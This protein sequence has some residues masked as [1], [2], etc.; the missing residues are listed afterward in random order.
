M[1]DPQATTSPATDRQRLA[2]LRRAY[3][4]LEPRV[5]AGE[6]WPLAD[7]FGVEPEASWGPREVLAHVAEMLPFWLGELDRIVL[8]RGHAP[9]PFGRMADDHLRIG[10][11]ERDRTLPLRV[12]FSGIDA[13]LHDWEL[14]LASL[15]TAD[16]AKVGVHVRLG[17]MPASAIPE[18][19][20][21]GH[22]EEHVSQLESILAAG[23]R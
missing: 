7:H 11:I 21:L 13:G 23:G 1:T 19:F 9:V 12:L 14:R 10:L 2:A 6:P 20:C 3:R 4:A 8:D 5:V 15:S 22:A 16:L 18:R 17:E